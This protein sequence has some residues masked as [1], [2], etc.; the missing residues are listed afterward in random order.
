M[1]IQAVL[2]P[3]F[4][5]VALTFALMFW[6]GSARVAAIRRGEAK[7]RD[8]ALGQPN[9]P[10]RVTQIANG[11]HNQFQLPLLF[12]AVVVLA[13]L[14]RKADLLFVI[15]SWAFVVLRVL[16]A[17][18]HTGTNYVPYRFYVFLAGAVVLLL[19]W[20]IFAVRML[21]VPG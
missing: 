7:I 14:T 21:F 8:T 3:V 15:L 20:V 1:S 5:Q 11:Y 17:A 16:H 2:L 9:W 18:I 13:L 19:V 6:M 4:V 10:P 12:Y